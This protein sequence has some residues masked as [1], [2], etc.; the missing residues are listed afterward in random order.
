MYKALLP[1]AKE[2]SKKKMMISKTRSLS[3]RNTYVIITDIEA[4]LA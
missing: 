1:E 2:F 3:H 4:R